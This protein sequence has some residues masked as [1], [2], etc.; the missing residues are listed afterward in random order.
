MSLNSQGFSASPVEHMS[1][2]QDGR[3]GDGR[4]PVPQASC[5]PGFAVQQPAVK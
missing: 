4:C 3:W 5:L 2:E 1:I